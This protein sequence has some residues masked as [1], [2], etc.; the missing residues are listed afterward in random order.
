MDIK[1]VGNRGI[2]FSFDDIGDITNVYVINGD[3]YIYIIDTFIG[4]KAMN[5]VNSYIESNMGE[6]PII[7]VNT[8]YHW[9]HVWGNCA[10]KAYPIVA[11]KKSLEFLAEKGEMD[12]K[13]HQEYAKGKVE[14][15]LPNLTFSKSLVFEEDNVRLFHSPGHTEDSITVYDAQDKVL[16]VGDNLERPIPYLMADNLD[17]YYKTLQS[18]LEMDFN[19]VIGGHIGVEGKQLIYDNAKYIKSFIEGCA[20]ES[21]EES[22]KY[23]HELN[24]KLRMQE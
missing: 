5:P 24:K 21:D 2:L 17:E 22:Y 11:N 10:Y 13:K 12:L 9:D 3:R 15:T 18:Y 23:I 14:I 16:V 1:H 8:H 6:K 7:V 4:P 20:P 19:D